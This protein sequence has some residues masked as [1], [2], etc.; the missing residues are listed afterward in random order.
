MIINGFGGMESGGLQALNNAKL[1]RNGGGECTGVVATDVYTGTVSLTSNTTF[2][3]WQKNS[4]SDYA[5][6]SPATNFSLTV[7]D[8]MCYIPLAITAERTSTGTGT[9]TVVSGSVYSVDLTDNFVDLYIQCNNVVVP[10]YAYS[11]G[12]NYETNNVYPPTSQT[13]F[14]GYK[15]GSLAGT[16]SRTTLWGSSPPTT[17]SYTW[18]S[19]VRWYSESNKTYNFRAVLV[20]DSSYISSNHSTTLVLRRSANV[21][22]KVTLWRPWYWMNQ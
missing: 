12:N 7:P 15:L 14:S 5:Y 6:Y 16:G 9:W 17:S 8:N 18:G 4:R 10:Q 11:V 20:W 3:R 22:F 13:S 2:T 1:V 19:G 21:T